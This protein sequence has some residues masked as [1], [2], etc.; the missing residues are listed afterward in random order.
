MTSARAKSDERL[1]VT[2]PS[3]D[4]THSGSFRRDQALEADL[5]EQQR[6]EQLCLVDR[7]RH[8]QQRL[9]R[10]HGS[11]FRDRANVP[12]KFELLQVVEKRFRKPL[13]A[14]MS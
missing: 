8:L 3:N 9:V 10:E 1:P 6:F 11:T 2:L 5:V 12:G 7:C 13:R 14:E 4:V